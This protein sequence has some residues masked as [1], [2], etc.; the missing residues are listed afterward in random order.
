MSIG[1]RSTKMQMVDISVDKLSVPYHI[2]AM[3]LAPRLHSSSAVTLGTLSVRDTPLL[4][5]VASGRRHLPHS[6][7]TV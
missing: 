2:I 3:L 5:K 4:M 7:S 1:R 6:E